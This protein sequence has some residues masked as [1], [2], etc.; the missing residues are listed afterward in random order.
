ML[1]CYHAG[2]AE[3]RTVILA[4]TVLVVDVSRPRE[5]HSKKKKS[6]EKTN[7]FMT[8]TTTDKGIQKALGQKIGILL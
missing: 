7:T 5:Q 3:A 1:P 4:G 2:R 6:R 8:M